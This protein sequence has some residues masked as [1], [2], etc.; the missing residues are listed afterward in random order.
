MIFS[1]EQQVIEG[2]IREYF[3]ENG[4]SETVELNWTPVPFSGEWGISTSLFK[5]AAQEARTGKIPPAKRVPVPERA[6]QLAEGIASYLGLPAGFHRIEAVRGYLNIYFS[7]NEYSRRV[8]DQV[9]EEGDLYGCHPSKGERVMVEFSQ[10]NT[11]K[12]FHVGH[13]RNVILGAAISNILECAGYEVVRSNYIGDI[14]LHVIKWLWNYQKNHSNE[15]P[16]KEIIRWMSDLYTEAVL[17]V[18][19]NPEFEKEVRALFARWDAQDPEIIS[20]WEKTRGWCLEGFEHLYKRLG[21]EFDRI[22]FES[23]VELEGKTIVKDLISRGVAIDE[24]PAGPV[25]LRLDDLLGLKEERYRVL[26]IL[27]SDDTSL[28]STKDLALAIKK[29]TEY[30]LDRSIYVIDVRQTLY[31]Q[32]IFKTIEIMG[33]PWAGHL[34][35][36]PYEIVNL[37]GNVTMSSREGTVVLLDDLIQEATQRAL[38]IVQEK[39]PDLPTETKNSV[40]E[41]VAF[42]A[43]KFPMLARD[44]TKIATFDW[45]S[46]LDFT[47]QAAPYIQYAHVRANSILRRQGGKLPESTFPDYSMDPKEIELIDLISRL[48]NE[49]GRA[50]KEYKT[51]HL[52]NLAYEISRAFNDFYK[53]C[54]VLKAEP[55]IRAAR[56][57][58]VA[59]ARQ[60]LAN[61]LQLM[62]INAP[63]VM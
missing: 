5:I 25:I 41:A 36:L 27:R 15:I 37:P 3:V 11:H 38:E 39:N 12:A 20:L 54:P 63:D 49:I 52:T 18:E 53:Q 29:F 6:Q 4:F 58:L 51:L 55:E 26:V 28:Y 21:I 42:G 60:T 23:E 16:T 31:L 43:I 47:G 2:S 33:Y 44:N 48:P 50:A 56:L 40:A 61:T 7:P 46:A 14:G 9:L 22:Y 32:Q 17:L 13:L 62:G 10:P 57:R 59:A 30:D 19:N 45:E 8:V 24:R 34:Y 1:K 35:H